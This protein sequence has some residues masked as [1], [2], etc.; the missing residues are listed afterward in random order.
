M[1][2]TDKTAAAIA[3]D[4]MARSEVVLWV[5]ARMKLGHLSS[6]KFSGVLSARPELT[7]GQARAIAAWSN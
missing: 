1:A 6:P 3:R 7:A 2:A 4:V 5:T